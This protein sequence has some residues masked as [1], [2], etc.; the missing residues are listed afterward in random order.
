MASSVDNGELRLRLRI[1]REQVRYLDDLASGAFLL[2]CFGEAVSALSI[3]REGHGGALVAVDRMSFRH[4]LHAGDLIEIAARFVSK[5]VTSRRY[6]CEGWL[7]QSHF[8]KGA[9]TV[10]WSV[11]DPPTLVGGGLLTIV[12]RP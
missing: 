3:G 2:Q 12:V 8:D 11:Y 4:A 9:R 7:L 10:D 1:G 6:E 5:G